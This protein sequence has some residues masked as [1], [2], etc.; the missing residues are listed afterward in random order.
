[1]TTLR[2]FEYRCLPFGHRFKAPVLAHSY[3]DLLVRSARPRSER[4]FRMGDPV[5]DELSVLLVE[6]TRPGS[7]R[8][9]E[10]EQ[11]RLFQL[12]LSAVLD[13]DC[14]GSKFEVGR[15]PACPVCGSLEIEDWASV[16]P[17]IVFDTEL[18]LATHQDWDELDRS[19]KLERVR[20]VVE[21]SDSS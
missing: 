20:G 13:P 9:S 14:D 15:P 7:T 2:L 6:L 19:G 17:A 21:R 18:P 3:G 8:R 5:G 10:R 1:M 12:A 11:G 16:E 4:L